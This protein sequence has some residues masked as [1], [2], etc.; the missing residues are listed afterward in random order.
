MLYDSVGFIGATFGKEEVHS[1]QF[2]PVAAG[3]VFCLFG[4]S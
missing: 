4:V 2:C 1:M 3:P